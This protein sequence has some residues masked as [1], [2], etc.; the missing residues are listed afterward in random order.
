[1]RKFD[2]VFRDRKERDFCWMK[3]SE[4]EE[5]FED[6][7]SDPEENVHQLFLLASGIR[8]RFGPAEEFFGKVVEEQYHHEVLKSGELKKTRPIGGAEV[9][10]AWIKNIEENKLTIEMYESQI[11]DIEVKLRQELA[12]D[13]SYKLPR[14][15]DEYAGR[16]R[17]AMTDGEAITKKKVIELA[18]IGKDERAW[19]YLYIGLGERMNL[20]DA[21]EELTMVPRILEIAEEDIG[22]PIEDLVE[23]DAYIDELAEMLLSKNKVELRE[24]IDGYRHERM[25]AEKPRTKKKKE[26][27]SIFPTA[28]V[29]KVLLPVYE[30]P[31]HMLMAGRIVVL[32]GEDAVRISGDE[33]IAKAFREITKQFIRRGIPTMNPNCGPIE[34]IAGNVIEEE[35]VN[36]LIARIEAFRV[37]YGLS[38]RR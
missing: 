19:P 22:R 32:E 33:Y 7:M 18:R 23:D 12:E 30:G 8:M 36:E 6:A 13:Y 4:Q 31:G 20:F 1:M 14:T 29:R 3:I 38:R 5:L 37:E 9:Q 15:F 27:K 26:K 28:P 2:E 34:Y 11:K 35:K 25:H 16:R 24:W 10:R 21:T 17:L